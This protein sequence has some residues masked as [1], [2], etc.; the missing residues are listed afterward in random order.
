M[1][2]LPPKMNDDEHDHDKQGDA[3]ITNDG[4]STQNGSTTDSGKSGETDKLPTSKLTKT[5]NY[6][7]KAVTRANWSGILGAVVTA[8][9]WSRLPFVR[10]RAS[11]RGTLSTA[12]SSTTMTEEQYQEHLD[13]ILRS[14]TKDPQFID[15]LPPEYVVYEHH[16]YEFI[17]DDKPW[18]H[19]NVYQR[20]LGN[21][22]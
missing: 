22:K 14:A 12:T 21:T 10:R 11:S 8:V 13:A 17:Y 7:T 6:I 15:Q 3:A 20:L 4:K 9:R 19:D 18:S 2:Q 1:K 16:R 5:S